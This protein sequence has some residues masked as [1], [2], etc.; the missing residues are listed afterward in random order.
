MSLLCEERV[1]FKKEEKNFFFS[2]KVKKKTNCS[3]C[4][5]LTKIHSFVFLILN[6]VKNKPRECFL[7][8]KSNRLTILERKRKV[9]M[10]DRFQSMK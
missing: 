8:I 1:T 10:F 6:E 3:R 4:Y 5:C 2:F 7:L 9:T